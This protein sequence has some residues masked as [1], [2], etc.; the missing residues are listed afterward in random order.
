MDFKFLTVMFCRGHAE[1]VLPEGRNTVR[2]C[3]VELGEHPQHA[4]LLRLDA[5]V[6]GS[7]HF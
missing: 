4:G 3:H 2:G 5:M 6:R 7:S 1:A